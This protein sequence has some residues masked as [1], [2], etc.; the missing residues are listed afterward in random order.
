MFKCFRLSENI[1]LDH[2]AGTSAETFNSVDMT[3]ISNMI[4]SGE[5]IDASEVADQLFPQGTPDIFLSHSFADRN[6]AL[7]LANKIQQTHGLIVFID[8]D[9]WGSVYDLLKEVDDEYCRLSGSNSY[10]YEKRNQST[11]HVYMILNSALHEVIDRTEAFI[12]LGSE[13]S[14]VP[15]IKSTMSEYNRDKTYSPWIHSELLLSSMIRRSRPKRYKEVVLDS[16]ASVEHLTESKQLKVE[17][18][19]PM[20]HLTKISQILLNQ[21]LE[22]PCKKENGLDILYKLFRD[23]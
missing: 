10:S 2:A 20:G 7:L 3:A 13:N 23:K 16:V 12:F 8:S 17:H 6:K 21:W 4:K 14:L 5:P 22:T 18:D 11:A 1:L 15:S 19:A 9:V